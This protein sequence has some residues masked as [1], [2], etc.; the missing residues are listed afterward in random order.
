MASLERAPPPTS[1]AAS[2]TVTC[3]PSLARATAAAS[4]LGPPPTTSAV[5]TPRSEPA[6]GR[7][8]TGPRHLQ[9]D[10]SVGQPRLFGHRVGHLPG[11]ALDDTERSVDDLVALDPASDGL[12]LH[13]HHDEF[14]RQELS[15]VLHRRDQILVVQVTV[16]EVEAD[17]RVADELRLTHG[18]GVDIREVLHQHREQSAALAV[19]GPPPD[20]SAA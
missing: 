7:R 2:S 13:P 6:V 16:A 20:R 3:T 10:G 12:R 4:P 14:A 18:P 1:S 11:T 8:S 9:R 5:L 17:Q 19:H 15:L